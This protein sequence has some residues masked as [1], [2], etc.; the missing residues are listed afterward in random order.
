MPG[1]L[2]LVSTSLLDS[3]E[4]LGLD[5][6]GGSTFNVWPGPATEPPLEP[7][8]Q[9]QWFRAS[10]ATQRGQKEVF[11]CHS[12]HIQG[13]WLQLFSPTKICFLFADEML[14]I[15]NGLQRDPRG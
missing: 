8:E 3:G 12:E 15:W 4:C 7:Q 1:D 6:L 14:H 2:P 10:S 5:T 11:Q 13:E 9:E